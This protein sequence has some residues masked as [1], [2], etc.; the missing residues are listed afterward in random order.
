MKKNETLMVDMDDVIV[1]GGFLYLINEYL[2]THYTEDDFKD[3]YM[4]NI[5]PDKQD[6][7]KFFL[8]KNMYDYCELLEH[9][10]EVLK[11]L[12]KVFKL[13]IVTSYLFP[14]IPKESGIVLLHKYNF[15]MEKL[16]FLSPKNFVFAVDKSVLNCKIRIDDRIDNLDGARKKILFTAYH[17]KDISNKVLRLQRIERAE[18]WYEVEKMLL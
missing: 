10:D 14:E 8:T 17:N 7:F 13:Y 16:P 4:Q 5:I 9:S 3:F 2:G 12:Y 15:L 18:N 6:F 11:K 1:K